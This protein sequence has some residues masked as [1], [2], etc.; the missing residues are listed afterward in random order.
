MVVGAGP[1]GLSAAICL[2]ERGLSVRVLE[3]RDT[4]GGGCRSAELTLPGFVHDVCSAIHPFVV[5]SP[6]LGR[7]P[8]DAHGLALVHPPAPVA[9]PLDDGT[10]VLLERGVQATAEGLRE[11]ADA[12]RRLM[13]PLVAGWTD[14][15]AQLLGPMIRPPRHPVLLAKFGVRGLRSARALADG[16]F[17]G[18]RARAL[19]AGLAAHSIL[20]LERPFTAGFALALGASAH[21]VG[22]P[23]AA[24][25]SQAIADALASHLRSLGGEVATGVRVER[26]GELPPARVSLF[27]V[28]PERLL[29][30]AGD[31]FPSGYRRKLAG[32]RRG[33]GVFKVDLALDGPVPWK[34]E[35]CARAG[36]VHLGGTMEEVAEAETVVARGDHPDRPFVLL[37]QPSL[38][39]P[40]RAPTGKHTVWAYCHVPNG[41]TVD[42]AERIERQIER[43]APGFAERILGRHTMSPADLERYNPNYAGGDIAGG[44]NDGLQLFA[45]PT[46]ALNPYRT[47]ARGLFLC[48]A[49]TPP[50]AGVHGMCGYHAA[51][52]ALR[53]LG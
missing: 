11:D 3:A 46:L 29:A 33:A 32:Y 22:W 43:F 12:Y 40:A 15:A 50:G 7:L 52:A 6:F 38:F 42:M 30:I 41:S 21:A 24:G 51:T 44:A 13:G 35:E 39:D 17:H 16:T 48:S 10:A 1:N 5:S 2:A 26:A 18:L 27:D 34:A 19:F 28:T 37:T 36:T 9:H 31:R 23:M 47:A 53:E 8:L 4:V 49:A 45:R 20:P 14:L 25:G